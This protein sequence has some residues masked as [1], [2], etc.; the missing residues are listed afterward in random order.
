M[1]SGRLFLKKTESISS[2]KAYSCEINAQPDQFKNVNVRSNSDIIEHIGRDRNQ[3]NILVV[4]VTIWV[5]KYFH[6][7]AKMQSAVW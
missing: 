4:S 7:S 1:S 3:L 5:R 2:F 6:D